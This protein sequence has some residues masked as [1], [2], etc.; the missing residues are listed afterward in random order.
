MKYELINPSD[1]IFYDA[2]DVIHSA[3][4]TALISTAY[5]GAC[6]EKDGEDSPI[7][8]FGDASEWIKE[9]SGIGVE[10]F[11]EKN[12]QSLFETFQSFR[13]ASGKRTS[14]NNIVGAAHQYAEALKK[15]YLTEPVTVGDQQ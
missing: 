15:K 9:R 2:P 5:G 1:K 6:Q 11:I 3:V 7:F 14:M 13:L 10:D 12:A 4:A 8:L